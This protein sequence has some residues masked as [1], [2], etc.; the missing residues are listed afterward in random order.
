MIDLT[1]LPLSAQI[2]AF[3][4][5]GYLY[6]AISLIIADFSF[7]GG[8]NLMFAATALNMLYKSYLM[9]SQIN[10]PEFVLE[11]NLIYAQHS[12]NSFEKKYCHE[13]LNEAKNIVENNP[14]NAQLEKLSLEY[15]LIGMTNFCDSDVVAG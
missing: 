2:T 11:S 15:D 13:Y 6:S 8:P 12:L 10:S 9:L 3:V 5:V 14:N 1:Q 4:S 7:F